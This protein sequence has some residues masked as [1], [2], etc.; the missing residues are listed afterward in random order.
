MEQARI[1]RRAPGQRRPATAAARTGSSQA[2]A[3]DANQV[4]HSHM[5][6]RS[7]RPASAVPSPQRR[8]EEVPFT[9]YRG[10]GGAATAQPRGH[11]RFQATLP[12]VLLEQPGSSSAVPVSGTPLQHRATYTVKG[13]GIHTRGGAVIW[14]SAPAPGASTHNPPS[15]INGSSLHFAMLS[16]TQQTGQGGSAEASPQWQR[17]AA[18]KA[19]T[20]PQSANLDRLRRP[21]SAAAA[22]RNSYNV[23]PMAPDGLRTREQQRR[24]PGLY[25]SKRIRTA[26]D[27]ARELSQRQDAVA[28]RVRTALLKQTGGRATQARAAA[29]HPK[30]AAVAGSAGAGGVALVG[31]GRHS[32]PVGSDRLLA[33]AEATGPDVGG[34]PATESKASEQL[35]FGRAPAPSRPSAP[36][37]VLVQA[38]VHHGGQG[39]GA[40]SHAK[41]KSFTSRAAVSRL[42]ASMGV[43]AYAVPPGAQV[44]PEDIST[45]HI[46]K[47]RF[48]EAPAD[49]TNAQRLGGSSQVLGGSH[50]INPPGGAAKGPFVL[51]PS[52]VPRSQQLNTGGMLQ[53]GIR[54]T[55]VQGAFQ[56][57]GKGGARGPI[58]RWAGTPSTVLQRRTDFRGEAAAHA[59]A[60]LQ[61][62]AASA[63]GHAASQAARL[64]LQ[65][66]DQARVENKGGQ[67]AWQR[68]AHTHGNSRRRPVSAHERPYLGPS[69]AEGAAASSPRDALQQ[70]ADRRWGGR[71]PESIPPQELHSTAKRFYRPQWG[72]TPA[73]TLPLP[74]G[75]SMAPHCAPDSSGSGSGVPHTQDMPGS[76]AGS[77]R[78]PAGD[79][80]D[81]GMWY[82]SDTDERLSAPRASQGRHVTYASGEQAARAARASMRANDPLQRR[83]GP[84]TRP[85]SAV[86]ALGKATH[87]GPRGFK[88]PSSPQRSRPRSAHASIPS[89]RIDSPPKSAGQRLKSSLAAGA[90]PAVHLRVPHPLHPYI[91]LDARAEDTAQVYAQ[92]SSTPL[93]D[94]VAIATVT[95]PGGASAGLHVSAEGAPRQTRGAAPHSPPRSP[96]SS[97]KGSQLGDGHAEQQA[98]DALLQGEGGTAPLPSPT[99]WG[100]GSPERRPLL[101]AA[102]GHIKQIPAPVQLPAAQQAAMRPRSPER[103]PG[104]GTGRWARA[105]PLSAK[106]V[107]NSKQAVASLGGAPG[108]WSLEHGGDMGVVPAEGGVDSTAQL[109]AYVQ[110]TDKR[111]REEVPSL[112]L[113]A[114]ADRPP[115]HADTIAAAASGQQEAFSAR[116]HGRI[117]VQTT[118]TPVQV[119]TEAAAFAQADDGASLSLQ[120]PGVLLSQD[121]VRGRVVRGPPPAPPSPADVASSGSDSPKGRA[122]PGNRPVGALQADT[123]TGA[124]LSPLPRSSQGSSTLSAWVAGALVGRVRASRKRRKHSELEGIADAAGMF[125]DT[126]ARVGDQEEG[127]E[128]GPALSLSGGGLEEETPAVSL[129]PPLAQAVV[130]PKRNSRRALPASPPSQR[131][132]AP[133]SAFDDVL[134]DSGSVRSPSADG[135]VAVLGAVLSREGLMSASSL[136]RAALLPA[137]LLP[138]ANSRKQLD[139][140][141]S[142]ELLQASGGDASKA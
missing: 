123:G 4:H 20:R 23:D 88:G 10:G 63:R 95:A 49:Y 139:S 45:Q 48:S 122:T 31:E 24:G 99:R 52:K 103:R 53:D 84:R 126:L 132:G 92:Y 141:A 42:A 114:G 75:D 9:A 21:T 118:G 117:S 26:E 142:L 1:P 11:A 12:E 46:R 19:T 55:G 104:S 73:H 124:S 128:G 60:V 17:T 107:P 87:A 110:A 13:G 120:D 30:S 111:N 41:T 108:V 43:P 29:A 70:V 134:S 116:A 44:Y 68:G 80:D 33:T 85:Q 34:R 112:P 61:A 36:H 97:G 22:K 81:D 8:R 65:R 76:A 135:R 86:G 74:S 137:P 119:A 37:A 101:L 3:P 78:P 93:T 59:E 18:A 94:A 77:T 67:L 14:G 64:A 47:Y 2:Q 32:V 138:Q 105:R 16:G 51:L 121:K 71:D 131:M 113:L 58:K 56:R 83:S 100:A 102:D 15:S 50:L 130:N 38:R 57:G 82:D 25:P 79:K 136:P 115:S 39:E 125:D 54:G 96:S 127:G 98:A 133:L 72:G 7:Q 89:P 28:A 140:S 90:T 106:A 6:L 62:A 129:P 27:M 40:A 5:H 35:L 69:T 91:M 66:Y 109:S